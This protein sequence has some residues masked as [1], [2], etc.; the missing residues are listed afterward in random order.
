[1][2]EEA[3]LSLEYVELDLN[4]KITVVAG[5]MLAL[6]NFRLAASQLQVHTQPPTTT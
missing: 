4:A 3:S 2:G 5:G 1:M 6:E